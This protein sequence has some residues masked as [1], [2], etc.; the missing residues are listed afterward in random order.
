MATR[1]ESVV[2]YAAGL[3]QGV[4]LVTFPATSTVLT[5]PGEYDLSATQYGVLFIP[6][7]ITAIACSLLGSRLARRISERRVYLIGLAASLVAVSVLVASAPFAGDAAAYP[8]P[9]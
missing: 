4:V 1:R 2:V 5:D 7:V 8:M 6:Q 3:G 9:A